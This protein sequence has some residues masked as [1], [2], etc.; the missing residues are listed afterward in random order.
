MTYGANEKEG[1]FFF[2]GL[3]LLFF[4]GEVW[5]NVWVFG[6]IL[7]TEKG[8]LLAKFKPSCNFKM[9]IYKMTWKLRT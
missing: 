3:S 6:Y 7:W 8:S 1:F 2:L 9:F 5:K 4:W